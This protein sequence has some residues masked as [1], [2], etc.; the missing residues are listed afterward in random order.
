MERERT[1]PGMH[2]G[3]YW[4]QCTWHA[5]CRPSLTEVLQLLFSD[6]DV[7]SW[8]HKLSSE[9]VGFD[10]RSLLDR[11]KGQGATVT[12]YAFWLPGFKSKVGLI[13]LFQ[14]QA[15]A[16]AS[17][18]KMFMNILNCWKNERPKDIQIP[19]F[20]SKLIENAL[21]ETVSPR[22]AIFCWL[23]RLCRS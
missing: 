13:F 5:R 16:V 14:A 8:Q 17:N 12:W 6:L 7:F 9:A 19:V 2:I 11:R 20:S 3:P 21:V 10:E 22:S 23:T 18:M 4:L 15:I 1:L